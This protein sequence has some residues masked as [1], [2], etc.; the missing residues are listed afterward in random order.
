MNMAANIS[1]SHRHQRDNMESISLVDVLSMKD[2]DKMYDYYP[3]R[4]AYL[5]LNGWLLSEQLYYKVGIDHFTEFLLNP[6]K[7]TS[8]FTIPTHF[9]LK[10]PS[11]SSITMYLE[12]QKKIVKSEPPG[13]YDDNYIS[14]SYSHLG[15]LIITGFYDQEFK[16]SKTD[17]WLGIDLSYRLNT[18]TQVSLFYG[19]QKGGLV[20]ANGIC[21]DQPG[22]A[23]GFKVSFMSLF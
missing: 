20:C 4:Q 23:D 3:F 7:N 9:V 13:E 1:L 8:A 16:D 14:L 17:K 15:K 18:Q 5:E 10:L 19:S 22:F 21:A 6:K 11:G 12:A 2:E